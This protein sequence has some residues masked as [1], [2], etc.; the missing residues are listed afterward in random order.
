MDMRSGLDSMER[1]AVAERLPKLPESCNESGDLSALPKTGNDNVW[2]RGDSDAFALRCC[3]SC[4]CS[5][6]IVC[7]ACTRPPNCLFDDVVVT[8]ARWQ[9]TLTH[10]AIR[11]PRKSPAV[12]ISIIRPQTETFR[13]SCT[14]FCSFAS[15]SNY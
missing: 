11:C 13:V 2:C 8:C 15:L 3:S 9:W 6:K 1:A 7:A 12:P 5:S 10:Q 14:S 4:H